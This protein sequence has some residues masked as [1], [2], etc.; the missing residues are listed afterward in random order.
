MTQ[1]EILPIATTPADSGESAVVKRFALVGA[2]GFVAPRHMQAIRDCGGELVAALDPH[3]S[4]GILDSYFPDCRFFTEPERFDR[5]LERQHR[6][7]AGARI[8]YISVCSPNHLHDAHVRL[9]LRV[10]AN[11]VCEK[12][13]VI[14][15]W[16]VDQLADLQA[17]SAGSVYTVLQLRLHPAVRVLKDALRSE[18]N[19]RRREVCLTYVTR[20]GAW[21]GSSW[22][23]SDE[24]SGG[25][26]MNIGIHFF[27]L[28]IHLFGAVQHSEVHLAQPSRMA[29]AVEL[30]SAT[31]RWFLSIDGDDLPTSAKQRGEHAYRSL[32]VDGQE[33]DLSNG[34]GDLHTE[35]YREILAGRGFGLEDARPSIELVYD[36]RRSSPSAASR[37]AHPML[38]RK[39][40]A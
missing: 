6:R 20:R 28:L 36:V 8:D 14:N 16:N 37:S 4:V 24:K 18:Q 39:R 13:L 12:P 11:A 26:A 35:V 23:G 10:G 19:Q 25:L 34:F 1:S 21:Y 7:G 9:A 27:D 31:A 29:G 40:A 3:D 15:P 30:E 2:A 32:T 33:I 38:T 17:E 5:F 22:K